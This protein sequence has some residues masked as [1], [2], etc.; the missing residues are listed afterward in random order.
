MASNKRKQQPIIEEEDEDFSESSELENNNEESGNEDEKVVP[1]KK[2]KRLTNAT[3]TS[4]L[5]ASSAV[6]TSKKEAAF[7]R[8]QQTLSNYRRKTSHVARF[9]KGNKGLMATNSVTEFNFDAIQLADT[10]DNARQDI[11]KKKFFPRGMIGVVVRAER[12]DFSKDKKK[13][14][15]V[16]LVVD[17]D[18]VYD[19]QQ[20]GLKRSFQGEEIDYTEASIRLHLPKRY[21]D[22]LEGLV[23]LTLLH[24]TLI[25]CP[26]HDPIKWTDKKDEDKSSIPLIMVFKSKKAL[27]KFGL[28]PETFPTAEEFIEEGKKLLNEENY[29]LDGP[30]KVLFDYLKQQSE[31]FYAKESHKS[32]TL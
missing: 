4:S 2:K 26:Q 3:T 5:A 19:I 29:E 31:R 13:N 24:G 28:I 32:N 7:K 20:E 23:D 6:T 17:V 10:Q 14:C 25:L 15:R 22:Q 1:L 9:G 18:F 12:I 30:F 21:Q 16:E 8:A 27:E 11:T